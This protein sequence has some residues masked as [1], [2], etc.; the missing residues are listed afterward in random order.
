MNWYPD[1]PPIYDIQKS[2]LENADHGPFY[3]GPFPKRKDHAAEVDFLGY[4]LRSPVGVPAGPLLN[5]KWVALAAQLGFD[6]LVYKTIRSAAHPGHP[7]PNMIYVEETGPHVA[8]AIG[9]PP[10]DLAALTVTNSFGMPSRSPDYLLADIAAAQKALSPGQLLVVSVV[11]TPQRGM[12]FCDD[13][14]QT[15]LFAKK[16]GAR[17]IEANFSCPN[18]D[19]AEGSLYADP[20]SV[21]TYTRAIAQAIHPVPLIIKVGE[22]PGKEPLRQLLRAATRGGAQ[23]ICGLNSVA[24][25]VTDSKGFPALGP[26]RATSGVCGGAIR[27]RALRFI[28]DARHILAEE[29]LPLV[30]MGCGGIGAPEHFD[31]FLHAGAQIALSATAMMWDPLLAMRYHNAKRRTP[32]S[33]R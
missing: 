21:E 13:F 17:V 7:L 19:T 24:M 15:A 2:Y 9:E 1:H 10:A 33:A 6:L 25:T 30:L 8:R 12:S 31:E 3:D 20:E 5:A 23:A 14:V 4:K 28:R 16:A 18:V 11:G 27:S 26:A 29:G 32:A 22:L